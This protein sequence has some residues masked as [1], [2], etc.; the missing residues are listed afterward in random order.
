MSWHVLPVSTVVVVLPVHQ[1]TAVQP[2]V[3]LQSSLQSSEL[4]IDPGPSDPHPSIPTSSIQI[5]RKTI[6]AVL[7]KLMLIGILQCAFIGT[8]VG[9][10]GNA[11]V[12]VLYREYSD[13]KTSPPSAREA[14]TTDIQQQQIF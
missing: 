4:I 14:A 2:W 10:A 5:L 1:L 11:V 12:Y 6:S 9:I 8:S 7:N 13:K 3:A